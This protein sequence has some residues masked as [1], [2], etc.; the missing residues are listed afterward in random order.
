[1]PGEHAS[2]GPKLE[3]SG[4]TYDP[5]DFMKN[6]IFYYNFVWRDFGETSMSS[7]LDMVKVHILIMKFK[8]KMMKYNKTEMILNVLI[9]KNFNFMA[10]Q[11]KIQSFITFIRKKDRF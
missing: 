2:C 6:K 8:I 1:M 11:I 9:Y 5:N 3:S 4:F 7:L 10:L